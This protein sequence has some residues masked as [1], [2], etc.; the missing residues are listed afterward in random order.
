M[1]QN[2]LHTLLLLKYTEVEVCLLIW[3]ESDGR[4]FTSSLMTT[5]HNDAMLL[6]MLGSASIT[7]LRA[8]RTSTA[9]LETRD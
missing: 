5:P 4:L 8:L 3:G 9:S 6:S 2:S 7:A 1:E